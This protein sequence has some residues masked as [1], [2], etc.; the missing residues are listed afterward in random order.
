MRTQVPVVMCGQ[1]AG[2]APSAVVDGP[3]AAVAAVAE[4]TA[5]VS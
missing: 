2:V 5:H 1:W 4:L 3:S